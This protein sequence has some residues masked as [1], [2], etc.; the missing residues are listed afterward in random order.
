MVSNVQLVEI[1]RNAQLCTDSEGSK[2][3][4]NNE[5]VPSTD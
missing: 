5:L 4:H 1:I 3:A 2:R